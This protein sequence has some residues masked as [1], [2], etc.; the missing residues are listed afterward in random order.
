MPNFRATIIN[1]RK[2]NLASSGERMRKLVII[3]ICFVPFFWSGWSFADADCPQAA[4]EVIS[5]QGAVSFDPKANGAWHTAQLN[6][7]LCEGGQIWVKPNSRVS[8]A[9]PGSD[10]LRLN[11]NTVLTLKAIN[12]NKA[13]VLDIVKGF[14]H[15][16]ARKPKEVKIESGIANAAPLG[17]EFAFSVDA[18]KATLWVY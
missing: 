16:I 7:K 12:L 6:E 14:I 13:S 11:E 2:P 1:N 17:T 3:M 10:V 5:L 9:L 15:F 4:A 8:L 18:S